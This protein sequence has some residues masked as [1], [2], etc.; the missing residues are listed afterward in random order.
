MLR[1]RSLTVLLFAVLNVYKGLCMSTLTNALVSFCSVFCKYS[2]VLCY[3]DCVAALLFAT[4]V[5]HAA[6]DSFLIFCCI[7]C[8]HV[9]PFGECYLF[10]PIYGTRSRV[11]NRFLVSFFTPDIFF[12]NS[13]MLGFSLLFASL[14]VVLHY[15][16]H[17]RGIMHE[18]IT[19]ALLSFLFCFIL[20]CIILIVLLHS[21]NL[22]PMCCTLHPIAH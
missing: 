14:F 7:Y 3:P 4:D 20:S 5:L 16:F 2:G 1:A 10:C 11:C 18:S 19:N 13:T 8:R 22:Q 9:L 6:P 12:A 15:S 17:M 21:C